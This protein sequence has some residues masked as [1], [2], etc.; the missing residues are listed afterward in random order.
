MPSR[1]VPVDAVSRNPSGKIDYSALRDRVRAAAPRPE[2][3]ATAGPDALRALYAK[4]L[5]LPEVAADDEFFALGGDSLSAARL[6]TQATRDL[7]LPLT[8]E[9]LL[10][11]PTVAALA[12]ALQQGRAR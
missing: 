5:G 7:G 4:V 10:G 8:L 1:I 9:M 11:T 3:A 2:A 6:V 12:A